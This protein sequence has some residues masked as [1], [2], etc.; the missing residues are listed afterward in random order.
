M[1]RKM[2]YARVRIPIMLPVIERGLSAHEKTWT[3]LELL[4]IAEVYKIWD[5]G[6]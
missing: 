2:A 6:K 1:V 3:Q 4:G 5:P